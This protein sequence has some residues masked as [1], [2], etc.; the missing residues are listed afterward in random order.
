MQLLFIANACVSTNSPRLPYNTGK[1]D[2][3][4]MYFLKEVVCAL[5]DE[6]AD[7]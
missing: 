5:Q 4:Q 1:Q 6:I 3:K 2:A 7:G